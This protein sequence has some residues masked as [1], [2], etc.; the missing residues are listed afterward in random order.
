MRAC[1]RVCPCVSVDSRGGAQWDCRHSE[2]GHSAPSVNTLPW[3]HPASCALFVLCLP[4]CQLF[5]DA[6][7]PL[8]LLFCVAAHLVWR[9]WDVPVE[10]PSL[11]TRF[12]CALEDLISRLFYVCAQGGGGDQGA[13]AAAGGQQ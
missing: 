10:R 7:A 12:F 4:A 11:L 9:V 6:H 3:I 8:L 13:L 5:C 2:R 1:V